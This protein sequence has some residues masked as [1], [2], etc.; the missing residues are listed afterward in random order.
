MKLAISSLAVLALL[1]GCGAKDEKKALE[2]NHSYLTSNQQD[3]VWEGDCSPCSEIA[4]DEWSTT[5]SGK[6]ASQK[7][8]YFLKEFTTT[9]RG[10]ER[11]VCKVP[12]YQALKLQSSKVGLAGSLPES[13]SLKLSGVACNCKRPEPHHVECTP[14]F[15]LNYFNENGSPIGHQDFIGYTAN[16]YCTD[17]SQPKPCKA[18]TDAE[19]YNRCMDYSF[20]LFS[21]LAK[22][23]L[24]R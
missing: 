11:N 20:G 10:K 22:Q 14:S 4:K 18:D 5:C 17:G 19:V 7:G 3:F 24:H 8:T 6:L 16:T 15:T 1:V 12:R 2:N 13:I 21:E 23:V 9:F